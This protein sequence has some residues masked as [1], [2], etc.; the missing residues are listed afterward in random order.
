MRGLATGSA[1]TKHWRVFKSA[2][3]VPCAWG[4]AAWFP[5]GLFLAAFP[6]SVQE[7]VVMANQKGQ[8]ASRSKTVGGEVS[9]DLNKLSTVLQ[10]AIADAL[11]RLAQG[12]ARDGVALETRRAAKT[13]AGAAR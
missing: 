10:A 3:D 8:L 5:S 9:I 2:R 11:Q 1:A 6:L 4:G 7:G 12:E 13:A